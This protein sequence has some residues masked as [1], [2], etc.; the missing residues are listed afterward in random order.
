MTLKEMHTFVKDKIVD[1]GYHYANINKFDRMEL[2]TGTANTTFF[3]WLTEANPATIGDRNKGEKVLEIRFI[4]DARQDDYLDK[5]EDWEDL[6][7]SIRST[8]D[9]GD[10]KASYTDWKQ[11]R[12]EIRGNFITIIFQIKGDI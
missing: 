1:A 4:G 12:T 9:S 7:K 6:I 3:M 11:Y 2:P 5:I 8:I 10:C